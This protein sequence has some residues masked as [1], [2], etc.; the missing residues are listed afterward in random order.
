MCTLW[1]IF[2]LVKI[3]FQASLPLVLYLPESTDIIPINNSFTHCKIVVKSEGN[4]DIKASAW[5]VCS[6]PSKN[7][8]NDPSTP[9]FLL[10]SAHIQYI[11]TSKD[12]VV[13]FPPLLPVR[14]Q[15]SKKQ[16]HGSQASIKKNV[17]QRFCSTYW[18]VREPVR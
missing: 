4:H 6:R 12:L 14:V 18:L 15:Y 3:F 9:N 5:T 8:G 13:L 16:N 10:F 11:S 17:C 2:S 1:P 7:T